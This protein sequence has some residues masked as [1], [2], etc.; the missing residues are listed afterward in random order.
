MGV[1]YDAEVRI[2]YRMPRSVGVLAGQRKRAFDHDYPDD[3]EVCPRTGRKL[4]ISRETWFNGHVMDSSEDFFDFGDGQTLW[5]ID[6]GKE[7]WVC[8]RHTVGEYD[9]PVKIELTNLDD[10]RQLIDSGCAELC[11]TG[12]P[13]ESEFGVWLLLVCDA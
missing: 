9:Q 5:L 6:D 1:D 12:V 3:F 13:H 8:L 7:A 2:G 4:W 11:Q 10:V